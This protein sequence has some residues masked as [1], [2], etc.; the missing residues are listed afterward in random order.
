MVNDLLLV[1]NKHVVLYK[2]ISP[3]LG[4]AFNIVSLRFYRPEDPRRS[5]GSHSVELQQTDMGV[6]FV[7]SEEIL[8]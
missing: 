4:T 2:E 7:N 3:G 1:Y 5:I 6:R 8:D